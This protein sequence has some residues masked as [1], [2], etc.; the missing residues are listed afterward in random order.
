MAKKLDRSRSFG[1]VFGDHPARY[2][3]DNRFFNGDGEEIEVETVM[4]EDA[5]GKKVQAHRIKAPEAA[6]KKP[7]PN[8]ASGFVVEGETPPEPD[9]Q[10]AAQLGDDDAASF[11]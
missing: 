9:D 7:R 1:E 6:P 10:V 2:E 5:N 8:K 11:E 4:V 3:Q